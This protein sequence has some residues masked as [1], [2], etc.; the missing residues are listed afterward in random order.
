MATRDRGRPIT[1]RSAAA[2]GRRGAVTYACLLQCSSGPAS[3]GL[4]RY[5]SV[6]P[7]SVRR[8]RSR[9]RTAVV[10]QVEDLARR[11]TRRLSAPMTAVTMTAGGFI[12]T[13]S[14][15]AAADE[16]HRT[17][18][19]SDAEHRGRL[20]WDDDELTPGKKKE[21]GPTLHLVRRRREPQGAARGFL[22]NEDDRAAEPETVYMHVYHEV[23][24]PPK[25]PSRK[26][27]EL[28][29]PNCS[30]G[31]PER[32]REAAAPHAVRFREDKARTEALRPR[33]PRSEAKTK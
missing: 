16:S 7:R 33:S 25:T 5:R 32:H 24:A 8:R 12:T 11:L 17:D 6:R 28:R 19:S 29:R 27:R 26:P 3:G 30:T 23:P 18:G 4:D 20:E 13:P 31:S 10:S 15:A 14:S 21:G 22:P 9:R 2:S 1:P